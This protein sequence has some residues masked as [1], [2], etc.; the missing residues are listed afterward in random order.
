MRASD[1]KLP[2][3]KALTLILCILS[4]AAF[5]QSPSG[6]EIEI[7]ETHLVINYEEERKSKSINEPH[8][9]PIEKIILGEAGLKNLEKDPK[10]PLQ[11]HNMNFRMLDSLIWK[12]CNV[13]RL[14]NN[15]ALAKWDESIHKGSKH[16]SYYQKEI[17]G[18]Q[19][20]ETKY[21]ATR[22]EQQKHYRNVYSG[23]AEICLYNYM[24][25]G[26]ITYKEAA[27]KI[28]QQWIDSPGHNAIMRSKAYEYNSFGTIIDFKKEFLVNSFMLKKFNPA[29]LATIKNKVP[30][31]I[32][33]LD[34]KP[35]K[36]M[37]VY[38][39]GNFTWGKI[40]GKELRAVAD[41]PKPTPATEVTKPDPKPITASAITITESTVVRKKPAQNKGKLQRQANRRAFKRK[42]RGKFR[43]IFRK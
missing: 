15:V 27:D 41:L 18:L 31:A 3:M 14:K 20:G 11:A 7:N 8:K 35:R 29:L 6:I 19:H 28:V 9:I 40:E 33:K 5:G 16:H 42:V 24:Q 1:L 13:F 32:D 26:H 22:R 23:A 30:S 36:S 17:G 25:I 4:V 43:R 38:S 39:T 37:R 10:K 34:Y 2:M 21:M 12:R